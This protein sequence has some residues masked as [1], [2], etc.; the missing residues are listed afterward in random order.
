VY[1]YEANVSSTTRAGEGNIFLPA[2]MS[3]TPAAPGVTP[4]INPDVESISIDYGFLK[5]D[6]GA[7]RVRASE[8]STS[9]QKN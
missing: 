3:G 8:L 1:Y 4:V 2:G 7:E 9:G 6:D 5:D